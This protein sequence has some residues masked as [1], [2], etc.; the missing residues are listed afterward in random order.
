MIKLLLA[1]TCPRDNI[2]EVSKQWPE[3]PCD[4]LLIKFL[5]EYQVY[6]IMRNYFL[7]EDG[8]W[9]HLVISSDDLVVKK[10]NIEWLLEVLEQQDLPVV[11]GVCNIDET[12]FDLL[13]ITPPHN[14]PE[15][16]T[17]Y[18]ERKYE[19][20]RDS[21]INQN[22]LD[23]QLVRVGFSGFPLMA[24]RRDIIEKIP[25]E[26]DAEAMQKPIE[27]GQSTDLIF[28][29]R[30][31]EEGIPIYADTKNFMKHLRLSGEI[32]VGKKPSDAVFY[33]WN[34]NT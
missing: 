23:H 12:D 33:A 5:P 31:M 19:F 22:N 25:F 14:I 1:V 21:Q 3:L 13:N 15:A 27:Y 16:K 9:T 30:C 8:D 24:I 18:L 28:C 29:Y 6:G 20:M 11:S 26:T 4:K 32:Q 17:P 2:E 7:Y 10:E 34:K